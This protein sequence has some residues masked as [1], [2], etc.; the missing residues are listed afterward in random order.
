[1]ASNN[2][3]DKKTPVESME[4]CRI[5][6][7]LL[8]TPST[9]KERTPNNVWMSEKTP[10][11]LEPDLEKAMKQFFG[12]FQTL[13]SRS[14]VYLLPH[15]DDVPLQDLV[16]TANLGIVLSHLANRKVAIVS[17][18]TSEPRRGETEYG[19]KFFKS[20]GYE[21]FVP[22]TKFEGEADLKY[23][24]GNVYIGGYGMRSELETFK[25]MEELFDMKIV[26]VKVTSEREYHLDCSI[27]PLSREK[28]MVC[29]QLFAAEEIQRIEEVT[30][31]IDVD[32][33]SNS[34]GICN[35]VRIGD[36]I[37]NCGHTHIVK[38]GTKEFETESRKN[39]L[40]QKIAKDNGLQVHF[41]E[42]D[43]Y[44]KSGAL[45]SCMVLHMNRYNY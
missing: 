6:S 23:L 37:F 41:V 22:E 18:F 36:T 11:E 35:C 1:M 9:Y 33:D 45:L 4:K 19:I 44:L 26:C 38:P 20:M 3:N 39:N 14:L 43:E 25:W 29:K 34:F 32:L 24:Y 13:A 31:I 28:T 15:P 5:P 16:F 40:L 27:F 10:N 30:E 7:F 12:F 21:T 8:S 2:D 42:L 17:N